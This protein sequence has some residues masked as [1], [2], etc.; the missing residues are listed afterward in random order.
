MTDA[1]EQAGRQPLTYASWLPRL[2]QTQYATGQTVNGT[3]FRLENALL[4]VRVLMGYQLFA[5]RQAGFLYWSL[6]DRLASHAPLNV[7]DMRSPRLDRGVWNLSSNPSAQQIVQGD[8][9]LYYPGVDGP[10]HSLVSDTR[11]PF[12]F[13]YIY[14]E[15]FGQQQALA[16]AAR[17]LDLRCMHVEF[18]GNV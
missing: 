7:S 16:A 14:G 10:L 2:Q 8:G 17:C 4:D 9:E 12:C 11:P 15:H 1:L 5:A 18:I 6:I 3:N 13:T